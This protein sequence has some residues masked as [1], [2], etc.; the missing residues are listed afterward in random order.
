[1][2]F[3]VAHLEKVPV[4]SVELVWLVFSD[5]CCDLLVPSF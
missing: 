4:P 5:A 1:M 2:E 3:L